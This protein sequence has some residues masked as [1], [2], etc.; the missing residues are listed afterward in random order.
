MIQEISQ[1]EFIRQ[2]AQMNRENQ[3]SYNGKC[4]LY[5]YLTDLEEDT[6]QKIELDIIALCCE[7]AE[8]KNL[9]EYLENYSTDI[10]KS[11]FEE[12]N[13]FN[14]EKYEEAVLKEIQEKTTL[15]KVDDESFIIQQY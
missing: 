1:S 9:K 4:A 6:I 10:N 12:E 5:D 15:I 11:D 3:F 8:F 2:F 14:A 7:Y 13:D